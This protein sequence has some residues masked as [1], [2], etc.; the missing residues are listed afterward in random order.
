M[1]VLVWDVWG[2]MPKPD[3]QLDARQLRYFD[4]LAALT[5]DPD[6]SFAEL[7]A[8]YHDDEG[9]RVPPVVFNVITNHPETV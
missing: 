8:L 3:T 2:A 4:R 9:V 1:E 6:A 7:M 5:R